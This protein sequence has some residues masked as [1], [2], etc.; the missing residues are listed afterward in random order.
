MLEKQINNLLQWLLKNSHSRIIGN[1]LIYRFPKIESIELPPN[2]SLFECFD[3]LV[4]GM[5]ESHVVFKETV[6]EQVTKIITE[7]HDLK[8]REINNARKTD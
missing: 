5:I 4:L 8:W 2:G 1:I 6:I 3:R 7:Y